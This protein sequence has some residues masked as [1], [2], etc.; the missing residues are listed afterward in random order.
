MALEG[1]K[2]LIVFTMVEAKWSN[3]EN[4]TKEIR[5]RS[6]VAYNKSMSAQEMVGQHEIHDSTRSYEFLFHLQRND[7]AFASYEKVAIMLQVGK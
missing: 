3:I 2:H 4:I 7:I 5:K 1:F 6:M